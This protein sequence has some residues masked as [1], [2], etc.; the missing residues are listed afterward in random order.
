MI[1]QIEKHQATC[2]CL[3]GTQILTVHLQAAHNHPARLQVQ[4]MM[5]AAVIPKP[6]IFYFCFVNHCHY[7]TFEFR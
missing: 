2:A 7:L 1:V 6:D 5:I 4:K 3:W